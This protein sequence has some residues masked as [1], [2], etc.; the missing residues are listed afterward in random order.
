MHRFAE[1]VALQHYYPSEMSR[2][3]SGLRVPLVEAGHALLPVDTGT[4]AQRL[5]SETVSSI[6]PKDRAESVTVQRQ[7]KRL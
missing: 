4:A 6:K 2:M 5:V 3:A 7:C 1:N